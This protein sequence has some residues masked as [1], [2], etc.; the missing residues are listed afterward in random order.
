MRRLLLF[1][2]FLSVLGTAYPANPFFTGKKNEPASKVGS[3]TQSGCFSSLLRVQRELNRKIAV[4]SRELHNNW[5]GLFPLTLLVFAYGVLHALGPGHGKLFSVFYFMSEKVSI[6]RG[7]SLSML[8]GLLHG[9][10]GVLLVLVLKYLLQVYSYLL[11]QNVSDVIQ[12]VSFLLISLLG[13]FFVL[14]KIIGKRC[15][16]EGQSS[17]KSGLALALSVSIIPC[18]GVVMIMLFCISMRA[19]LLGLLLSGVMSVGMGVT[20]AFIG[21]A[22]LFLKNFSLE[23]MESKAVFKARVLVEYLFASLLF[24]YGLLLFIGSF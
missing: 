23:W 15:S 7:L 18:P 6:P 8:V 5:W 20:I 4:A 14:Q 11:Q 9:L 12:K 16:N 24:L 2:L 17:K 21:L 3:Y 1:C 19:L 10:M 22:T 13:L